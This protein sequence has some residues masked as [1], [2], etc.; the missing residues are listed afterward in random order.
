VTDKKAQSTVSRWS[1]AAAI[2]GAVCNVLCWCL[3]N[4]KFFSLADE[5]S[6][7]WNYWFVLVECIFLAPMLVLIILLLVLIIL[8]RCAPV[9]FF[10]AFALFSILK[11]RV[12]QVI[13]FSNGEVAQV[14]KYD[15][16][17]LL[18]ILLGGVSIAV[19]LV[20]VAIHFF[21]F[22]RHALKSHR[23]AS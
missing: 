2:F 9:M 13:Q 10:Y 23:A 5:W 3:S 1:V 18:L 8:R 6:F 20:R 16:P 21:V 19:V 11:A 7:I 4:Y 22:I 15:S 12:D 14:D 17:T